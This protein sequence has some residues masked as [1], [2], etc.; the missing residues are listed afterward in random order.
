MGL[1]DVL[2]GMQNGPRGPSEPGRGGM[3]PITMGILGLLAWK[4]FGKL[5]EQAQPANTAGANMQTTN[6]GGGFLGG[7][8]SGGLGG[9]GG[10]LTGGAAGGILSGG[11]SDLVE[12]LRNSGHG[13]TADSWVGQG[14]NKPVN[15]NALESAFGDRIDALAQQLGIP[16]D[17]LLHGLSQHLPEAVNHLTPNGRLPNEQEIAQHL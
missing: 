7:A 9:L 13:D 1:M 14:P 17:E 3:S 15:P 8:G 10:L 11:L 5:R 6:S 4:A 2:N 12:K 16:R